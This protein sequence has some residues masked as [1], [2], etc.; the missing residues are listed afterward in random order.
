MMNDN[1]RAVSVVY[2]TVCDFWVVFYAVSDVHPTSYQV[3]I[4]EVATESKQTS[5][6]AAFKQHAGMPGENSQAPKNASFIR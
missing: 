2:T 3:S 6:I 5:I 1:I 4:T